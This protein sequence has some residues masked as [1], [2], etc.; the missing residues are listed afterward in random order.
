ML[1]RYLVKNLACTY[2]QQLYAMAADKN[3]TIE[4]LMDFHRLIEGLSVEPGGE[5]KDPYSW[6]QFDSMAPIK[7]NDKF[8]SK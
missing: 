2:R 5:P 3:N 1:R 4:D 8:G 7:W 6:K